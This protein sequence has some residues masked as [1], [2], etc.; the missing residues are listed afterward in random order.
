MPAFDKNTE[1]KILISPSEEYLPINELAEEHGYAIDHIS[2]LCRQG[3]I[4]AIRK[5]NGRWFATRK[6]LIEY[7]EKAAG[8]K[9]E[10]ALNNLEGNQI[11][12]APSSSFEIADKKPRRVNLKSMNYKV[13]LRFA[14]LGIFIFA[15]ISSAI[16]FGKN[17]ELR[18]NFNGLISDAANFGKELKNIFIPSFK[19]TYREKGITFQ[20]S[21]SFFNFSYLQN[22]TD[23]FFY[24]FQSLSQNYYAAMLDQYISPILSPVSSIFSRFFGPKTARPEFV[25]GFE[26]QIQELKKQL[27][28]AKLEIRGRGTTTLVKEKEIIKEAGKE[29]QIITERK[30]VTIP[31]N[32]ETRFLAFEE[33]FNQID[34]ALSS[35][36][37]R[38]SYT[39]TI[40]IPSG[41]SGSGGGGHQ[42]VTISNP[43]TTDSETVKASNLLDVAGDATIGRSLNVDSGTFYVNP[44][45][46][47]VGIGTTSLETTLEVAGTASISGQL[48]V[49]GTSNFSGQVSTSYFYAQ[50]N[51]AASPSFSF[52][53]DKDTGFFSPES[54]AIAFS[55][56]STE[57]IRIDNSGFLGVG[58]TSPTTK[59]EV[60]GTAS[61]SYLLTGNTLQVG[62]FASVAYSRFGTATSGY[63]SFLNSTN[64]LL[65]S[66]SL[67]VDT[68]SFFDSNASIAGNFELT[69]A[70][71]LFGINA[72]N[73]IN[74][75]LEVGG[76]ASISGN[77][78]FGSKA[79]ISSNL[80]ISG[81]FIADTAASHSFTG[82]LTVSKEFV[83]SGTGSSSFAGS[84]LIS[85]GFNA[86]AIVGTA[87]TI[88]GNASVTGNT[89][90]GD[91]SGDTV[92]ANADAWTFAN[93]TNFTLSGGVNG[94]SFDT[95]TLS[96]DGTNNRV[97]VLTTAPTTTFEVQ[98]TASASYLLTGNTLQVGG[99]ASAAYSR[100][101]TNT[102]TYSRLGD[103]NDLLITDDLEVDGTTWFDGTVNFSGISSAS[104]FYA[105]PGTAASPSFAFA[106]DQ[107][108]GMFRRAVN[109]LGFSTLGAE[110]LTILSDGNVGI[111]TTSPVGLLDVNTKF[112]VLSGGNVGV[113]T[114]TPQTKFEVQGT[115]SASYLLTGNTLQVGG[116]ASVAYS[117][118]GTDTTGH[119][120]YITTTNDLLISGDLEV[121]SSVA[122]DSHVAI[123]DATDG[124]DLLAINAQV[125]SH[126]IPFSNIYDIG[127]TA[128]RWR[129]IWTDSLDVTNLTAASSS[130]SGTVADS[131]L[132][133]SDNTTNDTEDSS[134]T[135]ER[136]SPTT[137]A[138][139]KWDSTNNR[140]DLNFPVFLQTAD[141]SE[142]TSNFTKLILK[143]TTNQGSNDYFEI[144][145]KDASRLFIVESDGR[146]IA[147]SSFQ[148]GGNSVAS[149]AYSR[150]GTATTGYSSNL[151][152]ANDLLISGALEVDGK[153]FFD[154][155]ASISDRLELTSSTSR[156]G[157]NA[158]DFTN[159][160]L[161]VGGTASI[162]GTTTLRGVTYTWPSTDGNNGN[163][164]RTNGSG[165]LS[166]GVGLGSNSLDFDEFVNSMT[167]DANLT[168][169]SAGYTFTITD[170]QVNI[171]NARFTSDTNRL[172][173]NTNSPS[174]I[175]EVQGTASASYLLTGNTLQVG[176]FASVAY[177]RF[178]TDTTGYT[179]FITTTNDVLVSGDLE[180]NGSAQFDGPLRVGSGTTPALYVTS[181]TGNVGIG[182][183]APGGLLEVDGNLTGSTG[184]LFKV[185]SG[186]T[187]IF[188]VLENGN[189]GI[190]TTSPANLLDLVVNDSNNSSNVN[191]IRIAH[192]STSTAA[193]GLASGILFVGEDDDASS[194]GVAQSLALVQGIVEDVAST[195]FDAGLA[196]QVNKAGTG[197]FE[198][199]RVNSLGNVGIGTTTPSSLLTVQGRAEVQGTASASYLLTGNTLQ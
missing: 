114:T 184:S 164:L 47:R 76:T 91:A 97:G 146:V 79:S 153:V 66:G 162:S 39:P 63:A 71:P 61:A 67:E 88:N 51:T 38:F 107:D 68:D 160:M 45:D 102:T 190:G 182:I 149:A 86:Q 92:T 43:A 120:N 130:I 99:F 140:F 14:L 18:K 110:R 139:L 158:G 129:K 137:N 156:L 46:N 142:A 19:V 84:L 52:G 123:G 6:S 22:E 152:A 2:R 174:T 53:V 173:I 83:S 147:S 167:L 11:R 133:N 49:G 106:I 40:L 80:Q 144:Q 186:S 135:F 170:A 21:K 113:N 136:G 32:I 109:A 42:G 145:N 121:N 41:P 81:R 195:S 28:E 27:E 29:K 36:N 48:L 115:A 108:T 104:L 73:V 118:F 25:E 100:I 17:D 198:A 101:G 4:Q 35:V 54:N 103:A 98:G 30:I 143:G 179:N 9:K 31:S 168:I 37:Q 112:T 23:S 10:V 24:H 185:S 105:Q 154:G 72:G 122:F 13:G 134:I 155:T 148:A 192:T 50:R 95:N 87:L 33:K 75:T 12:L 159:T 58:T 56:G 183:A 178:G 1:E 55:T 34:L 85:K 187:A 193:N 138:V 125:R 132:I 157:I 82:D 20:L 69:G 189:V 78:F 119:S 90:L 96:I 177:S 176:G 188:D 141:P 124:T 3:R 131:F 128:N 15:M 116:F 16:A 126:I 180:I 169:A 7:R 89:T 199:V 196:I 166:W 194:G 172:G 8:V 191:L 59:F 171:G 5:E 181:A 65:I 150:F 151:D 77:A 175:L 163:V 117:R 64:D 111:G 165:T 26:N 60:Q 74:N 127:S 57:R 161:E 62:G 93:D 197:L 70:S 94:L 44:T